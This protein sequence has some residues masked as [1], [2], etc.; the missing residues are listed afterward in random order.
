[1]AITPTK[2]DFNNINEIENGDGILPQVI[3][4]PLKASAFVQAVITNPINQDEIAS[5]TPSVSIEGQNTNAPYIKVK[6][7]KG[8][9]GAK[10]V[11]Q[12]L[13]GQDGN[14]GNIYLQTFDD[15]T[16]A[17]FTA[18]KGEQ[19][20]QGEQGVKGDSPTTLTI[21]GFPYNIRQTTDLNDGGLAGY[22]TFIVES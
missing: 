12:V 8:G 17:T 18:P 21:N 13:Q 4:A 20:I 5:G 16:T 11:S 1:M 2:I 7:L 9:T 15:G 10:L 22:V 6:G 19:G 3:N 14:G